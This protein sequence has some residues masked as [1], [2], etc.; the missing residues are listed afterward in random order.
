VS[1]SAIAPHGGRGKRGEMVTE[2]RGAPKTRGNGDGTLYQLESGR[3]AWQI[4]YEEF[5]KV[6]RRSGSAPDK[7][8]AKNALDQARRDRALGLLS[9]ADRITVQ[10]LGE[11]WLEGQADL[12]KRAL[13]MGTDEVKYVLEVIGPMKVKD[14]QRNTLEKAVRAL[15]ARPMGRRDENGNPPEDATVMSHRTVGKA[16]MR[17]KALF[18]YAVICK[19]RHDNPSLGLKRPKSKTPQAETV[20]TV[21]DIDEKARFHEIGSAL[22]AAGVCALWP[23]IFTALAVG[24]RRSEVMGLRWEDVDFD[25]G[26]LKV[27]HTSVAQSVGG[28][29][30]SETTKTTGSRRDIDLP[31]SLRAMLTAHQ[32]HQK[33]EQ[34]KAGSSWRDSGAVFATALGWWISPDNLNRAVNNILG[35]SDQKMLLERYVPD[36]EPSRT[37]KKGEDV[38][39]LERRMRA[40]KVDHRH[41]LE[42]IVR[43]G[44][45]LPDIRVHDLRHTYA[46]TALRSRV[47]VA[48]VSKTLGHARISITLDIYRHV[49]PS[50]MKENVFDMFAVPVSVREVPVISVN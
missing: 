17:L 40:V 43:A 18:E 30:L 50:E 27:R 1:D 48:V 23:A 24:L 45:K 15:V 12:G 11:M 10:E 2:K 39:N 29:E 9:N 6:K 31:S 44:E 33:L 28:F 35:W 14:V 22:Y 3:W 7:T 37:A 8:A 41:R 26:V 20:G 4:T 13:K 16:L 25:A 47:P 49:L 5:G 32:A 46:T 34:E 42:A 21:L 36:G 38:T 19:I